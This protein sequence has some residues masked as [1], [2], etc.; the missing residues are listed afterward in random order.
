MVRKLNKACKF[1]PCHTELEDCTFCYCPFY[2]CLNEDKGRFIYSA[3]FKKDIWS[4][5]SC[6]WIHKSKVTENIFNLIRKKYR[7]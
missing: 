7:R 2:P 4:C 1:F 3:K 6:N 5:K